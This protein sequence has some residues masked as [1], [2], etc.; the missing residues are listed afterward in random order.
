MRPNVRGPLVVLLV[1]LLAPLTALAQ[2]G[3]ELLLKPWD[4]KK[5]IEMRNDVLFLGDG[6]FEDDELNGADFQLTTYESEGRI[7]ILPGN[8]ASPRIGYDV[9]YLDID[10]DLP[11]FPDHL[12]DQAISA[13]LLLAQ[14]ESGWIMGVTLG[15]GYAGE[16][17]YGDGKATY[18]KGTLV[19]GRE[20]N[21]NNALG[22]VIDYDANRVIFPDIPLPGFAWVGKLPERNL[23]L[24]LGFPVNSVIWDINK[25]TRAE[26]T[27]TFT[28]S[29][30]ARMTHDVS[31]HWALFG[32]VETRYTGFHLEGLEETNDRLFFEQRRVEGG[33]VWTPAKFVSLSAAGGFAFGGEFSTGWDMREIDN[34]LEVSDEPYFRVGVELRF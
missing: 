1:T 9:T 8:I 29:F 6:E 30:D 12:T 32:R 18:F 17:A 5:F 15:V 11:G 34:V 24:T 27:Y 13:G 25:Q 28:D 22:F 23:R 14:F 16:T 4:R 2:S 26:F 21:D 3:P 31:P 19:F 20:V 33:V 7:R 10:T